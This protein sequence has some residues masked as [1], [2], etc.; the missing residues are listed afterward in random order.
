MTKF[1]LAAA[2]LGICG[3]AGS[4]A[5][6]QA[7]GAGA[8]AAGVTVPPANLILGRQAG[9][10][11]QAGLLA[12][13]KAAL[14]SKSDVKPFKQPGEALAKWGRAIPGLF[15]PGTDKG[16]DTKARPA[17]FTDQAGFAK[18]AG[19]L[20]EAATKLADAAGADDKAA[21][22]TAF[23]Q[24]GQACGGCHRSYRER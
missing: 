21:F 23:Q 1:L 4:I 11:M 5:A 18:A 6:A 8:A 16:A 14:E 9:M 20:T 2:L 17:V 10:D 13:M 15:V 12:S 3:T 24:V 7:Q 19:N 22:A